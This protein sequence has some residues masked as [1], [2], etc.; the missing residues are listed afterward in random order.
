M[1]QVDRGNVTAL[2]APAQRPRL[3][4]THCHGSLNYRQDGKLALLRISKNASTELMNRL[5][6]LD[7]RPYREVDAPVVM[8]LRE[9]VRRF[10]S[11]IGE[12]LMRV[13]HPAIEDRQ[14][15]D[16]VMISEDVY[17]EL[18]EAIT[19]PVPVVVD[20]MLDLVE[21]QPFDAHHEPQI[22]FF[23]A[24]DGSPRFDGRLYTVERIE[25]GL[26]K[27]S[28]RYGIDIAPPGAPTGGRF[29]AGGAKPLTGSTRFRALARR[30]T[31]TGLYRRLP[32]PPLL[33]ARYP[34]YAGRT[35][36][37]R[38]LNAM[39]NLFTS[40]LK[41]EGLSEAQIARVRR[42]YQEDIAL[43]SLVKDADDRLLSDFL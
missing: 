27:I 4:T 42:I 21:E 5:D 35:L 1:N 13:Q 32:R 15:R 34:E 33:A 19:E 7:W 2:R 30:L 37:R 43:W 28:I 23:T 10:V 36:L 40:E 31:G 11:S 29:N 17:A 12:T 39:A 6:C 41:A 24:R 9:P 14:K 3:T 26:E 22:Y 20:A 8:F 18:A 38:D 25:E 16:R